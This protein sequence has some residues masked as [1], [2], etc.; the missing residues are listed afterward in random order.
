M[1]AFPEVRARKALRDVGA[2]AADADSLQLL[3]HTLLIRSTDALLRGCVVR[4][5]LQGRVYVNA[6]DV[7][8]ATLCC[9][10]PASRV[11]QPAPPPLLLAKRFA[12]FCATAAASMGAAADCFGGTVA[13]AEARAPHVRLSAATTAMLRENVERL[14]RGFIER[15]VAEHGRSIGG[16]HVAACLADCAGEPSVRLAGGE[17]ARRASEWIAVA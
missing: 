14:I 16:A 1:D 13:P 12:A 2:A 9:H 8:Y 4:C 5:L 15:L 7:Q 11:S 6:L 10:L 3:R 17:R